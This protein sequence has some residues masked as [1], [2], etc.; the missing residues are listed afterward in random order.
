MLLLRNA[1]LLAALVLP[2]AGHA[3]T[4]AA[5]TPEQQK[6]IDQMIH[7]YLMNNPKVLAEALQHAEEVAKQ[8]DA[9]AAKAQIAAHRD[10]LEHDPTSPVLGDPQ[11][12]V[13][14][15]EFFD[16]RCP[17]CKSSAPA[18][19]A[20]LDKDHRVRLVL[21]EYPILG[22]DSVAA[23]RISLVAWRHGKYA[24]YHKAL[25]AL[26]EKATADSAMAV[27]KSIGLDPA[28]VKKEME[29]P[30]I[31]QVIKHNYELAKTLGVDGTPAFIVG[32]T[33]TES[34]LDLDH[35]E[36]LVAAARKGQG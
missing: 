19:Q 21:K 23:A 11:G 5:L 7:D 33:D 15:V 32:T 6:A 9:D 20:L 25:F 14:V 3:A 1:A 31:D 27:A 30:E 22:P 29:S 10:E 35:L 13:T 36:Q 28:M 8:A 18:V 17:Y 2:L 4:P 26:K 34:A 16:Y 24:E 12:D